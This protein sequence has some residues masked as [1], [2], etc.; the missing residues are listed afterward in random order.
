MDGA[1]GTLPGTSSRRAVAIRSLFVWAGVTCSSLAGPPVAAT[2][3]QDAGAAQPAEVPLVAAPQHA[4]LAAPPADTRR[5]WLVKL[6]PDEL[7]YKDADHLDAELS[8]RGGKRQKAQLKLLSGETF[9]V[10]PRSGRFNRFD[11]LT[12]RF[13]PVGRQAPDDSPTEIH[14]EVAEGSGPDPAAALADALRNAVRQAVGVYVDSET[15]T[16]KEEI[17]HDKVLTFSDAFVVHYEELSR[18]TEAGL[19]TIK[20]SAAIQAG[21]LMSN[22]GEAKV[23]TIDLGG[24]DLVAAA[25]TRRDAR[26]A[27]ADL[28]FRKFQDLPGTLAA[29]ALPFKPLDYDVERR[30]LTVTYTLHA[31]RPKYDAFLASAKPLLEQVAVARTSMVLKMEPVW[32]DGSA[33][34][35]KDDSR[36]RQVAA[37]R[38]VYNPAF[39]YG[40]SLTAFPGAWC[41]WLMARWDATH[42]NSQ[43][44]GYALDV[45]LA[46]TLG[47]VRGG[48]AVRLDLVDAGGETV[49]SETH[50]PLAGLG[51]PAYWFGWARPRPRAFFAKNPRSWPSPEACPTSPILVATFREPAF[52][53]D[54]GR[55]VNVY[56]SPMCYAPQGTAPPV[57]APGAWKVVRITIDPDELARVTS[58]RATPV[59]VPADAPASSKPHTSALPSSSPEPPP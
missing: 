52:A 28:L 39:R 23:A 17:I 27:A 22:L 34:V 6:L 41:L 56:V 36:Q 55:A 38:G 30:L 31:D 7:V 9:R 11:E 4:M 42:R 59:F 25:A 58:I 15:L 29:E 16:D 43:W 57:V 50:D 33:P 45:D 3:P 14:T 49:R 13:A 44:Q 48:M 2:D 19:V 1:T 54:P 8:L 51:L 10:D 40:P 32:S 47:D 18:S 46:R 21:K 24:A 35:W 26:D 20:V 53:V 5:I 12:G 37:M